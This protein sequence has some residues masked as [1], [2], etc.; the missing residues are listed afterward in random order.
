MIAQE[1]ETAAA[2]ALAQYKKHAADLLAL[3]K[4]VSQIETQ[5]KESV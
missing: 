3:T 4:R 1:V 5:S 2:A